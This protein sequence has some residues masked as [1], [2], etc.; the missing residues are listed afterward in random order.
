MSKFIITHIK[1]N[2]G[3]TVHLCPTQYIAGK[4]HDLRYFLN[5]VRLIMNMIFQYE[6]CLVLC[7][8]SKK[9]K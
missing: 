7:Y 5:N 4:V 9:R 6:L 2:L 3:N 1:Y 8:H